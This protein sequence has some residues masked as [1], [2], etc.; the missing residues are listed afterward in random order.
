MD[1]H[2]QDGMG[3]THDE[4]D[5]VLALDTMHANAHVTDFTPVMQQLRMRHAQFTTPA[6]QEQLAPEHFWRQFLTGECIRVRV[7]TKKKKVNCTRPA[8]VTD[9]EMDKEMDKELEEEEGFI[10]LKAKSE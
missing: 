4:D 8:T 3:R 6:Q 10:M 7:G 5:D 9:T 1:E 2:R